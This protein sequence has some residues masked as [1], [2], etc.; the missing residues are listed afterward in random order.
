[1]LGAIKSYYRKDRE[2]IHTMGDYRKDISS[3]GIEQSEDQRNEKIDRVDE[4][5]ALALKKSFQVED[6]DE[7]LKCTFVFGILR[8]YNLRSV[9]GA[10][11]AQEMSMR[12]VFAQK[13]WTQF[14]KMPGIYLDI[15]TSLLGEDYPERMFE[16]L[17]R[18]MV[19]DYNNS[20]TNN[21]SKDSLFDRPLPHED[22]HFWHYLKTTEKFR[23][24][25]DKEDI[26]LE[27]S[28]A[29]ETNAP[30]S[31][32]ALTLQE[33]LSKYFTGVILPSILPPL[34]SRTML[35]ERPRHH[36]TIKDAPKEMKAKEILPLKDNSK[37]Q[38]FLRP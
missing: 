9:T 3:Y 35:M 27:L 6:K 25:I 23:V 4:I 17:V 36:E 32:I 33:R 2:V 15:E 22:R 24:Q 31:V 11:W 20:T 8:G 34:F 13:D 26:K 18:K 14:R 5:N 12:W 30:D 7:A 16:Q 38:G 19:I 29:E 37:S 1:M 10:C 28:A 21:K